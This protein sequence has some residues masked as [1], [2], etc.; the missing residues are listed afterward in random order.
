MEKLYDSL[1][2]SIE[3]KCEI[4][5]ISSDNY[6][7]KLKEFIS[8]KI[9]GILTNYSNM[10]NN[11]NKEYDLKIFNLIKENFSSKEEKE[12]IL[13][14]SICV[15]DENNFIFIININKLLKIFNINTNIN[16][17][18]IL[19]SYF[20][21]DQDFIENNDDYFITL[22]CFK[23]FCILINT[24]N[25]KEIRN[26]YLKIEKIIFQF[27]IEENTLLNKQNIN[28]EYSFLKKKEKSLLLKYSKKKCLYIVLIYNSIT[29]KYDLIKFGISRD[30]ED[31]LETHKR[32][33][34]ENIILYE[35][36]ES[37]HY[38]YIELKIKK[39]CEIPN[40]ILFKKRTSKA[41]IKN[42]IQTELLIIDDEF[43]SDMCWNKFL[44]IEK[45]ID[46]NE[47]LI[48]SQNRINLLE[49][50]LKK[51]DLEKKLF[52]NKKKKESVENEQKKDIFLEDDDIKIKELFIFGNEKDILRAKEIRDIIENEG[53][54]MSDK[55]L[56]KRLVHYG[57]K[58]YKKN[59]YISYLGIR[60]KL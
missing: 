15:N 27:F 7:E 33:I 47:A 48:D 5:K 36:L 37:V 55:K 54:C 18:N 25:S 40:D 31:R 12:F 11:D 1:N 2:N 26:N 13:N 20:I 42:K 9:I 8:D 57:A 59:G 51:K 22:E 16:I 43:T 60:K 34:G 3:D 23:S 41:F 24:Q 4:K 49:L 19:S 17:K 28:K 35:C 45:N 14:L 39:L 10:L 21:L 56:N 44:L 50:E 46:K 32:E 53:I 52:L 6:D 38:D 30:I 29:K 58:K